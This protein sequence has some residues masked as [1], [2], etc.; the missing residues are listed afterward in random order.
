MAVGDTGVL[1]FGSAKTPQTGRWVTDEVNGRER[2][3]MVYLADNGKDSN[4]Q[5][6]LGYFADAKNPNNQGCNFAI[7]IGGDKVSIQTIG[8]AKGAECKIKEI[9]L[10][11]FMD[12]LDALIS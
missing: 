2:T 10:S 9:P 7:S 3:M 6:Y 5:S 12:M 8:T 4:D 1:G 11:K